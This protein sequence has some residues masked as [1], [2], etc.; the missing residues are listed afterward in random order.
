[1]SQPRPHQFS[2][3]SL[4]DGDYYFTI[5]GGVGTWGAAPTSVDDV[6]VSAT[7]GSPA[8]MFD[9]DGTPVTTEVP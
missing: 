1:M 4:P 3:E 9:A 2:V 6:V 7:N 5:V 8:F